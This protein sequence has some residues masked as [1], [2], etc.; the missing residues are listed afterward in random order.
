MSAIELLMPVWIEFDDS[1]KWFSSTHRCVK[2]HQSESAA[3]LAT[4]META[5]VDK[6]DN[7]A[8]DG[9]VILK[10]YVRQCSPVLPRMIQTLK[11]VEPVS[12]SVHPKMNLS[13]LPQIVDNTTFDMSRKIQRKV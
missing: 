13:K 4:L 2:W 3:E 11:E 8:S 10:I 9:Q 1:C 12:R 7:C 5:S 6:A